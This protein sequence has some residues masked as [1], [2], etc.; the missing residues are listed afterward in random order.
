MEKRGQCRC[1]TLLTFDLTPQGYKTRCH[2]CNSVVR[3]RADT[4]TP[5][6]ATVAAKRPPE[7][8]PLVPAPAPKVP[9][10]V[11]TP[12]PL[13]DTVPPDL[14][15]LDTK[16][17]TAPPAMVEMVAFREELPARKEHLRWVIFAVV[18]ALLIVVGV[19][20][21]VYGA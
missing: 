10:P 11:P 7:P 5:A 19:V 4:P 17:S 20:A 13:E 1:G 21:V 2:V 12:D 8:P 16:E 15:I 18:L 6:P 3:L 9:R 14:S